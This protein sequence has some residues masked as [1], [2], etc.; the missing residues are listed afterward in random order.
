MGLSELQPD[1][2]IA[3]VVIVGCFILMGFGRD[4]VV[5]SILLTTTGFYFGAR[6]VKKA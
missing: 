4:G 3:I 6:K 2:V 1:E 5:T